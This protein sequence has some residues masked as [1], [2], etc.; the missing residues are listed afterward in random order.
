MFFAPEIADM[1][2]EWEIKK[3]KAFRGHITCVKDSPYARMEPIDMFVGFSCDKRLRL[4]AYAALGGHLSLLATL[5]EYKLYQTVWLRAAGKIIPQG[6]DDLYDLGVALRNERIVK[7]NKVA[8]ICDRPECLDREMHCCSYRLLCHLAKT[9]L[10]G[11]VRCLLRDERNNYVEYF[12]RG[13]DCPQ[14]REYVKPFIDG[15]YHK[16]LLHY[17]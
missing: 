11:A 8:L 12:L 17:R 3:R 1:L 6:T 5:P 15:Y 9:N 7:N 2:D 4:L 16:I 13:H 10:Q 14:M